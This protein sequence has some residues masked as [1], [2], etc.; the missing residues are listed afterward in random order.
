MPGGIA[1]SLP[2]AIGGAMRKA[3]QE[4]A[5]YEPKYQPKTSLRDRP[6]MVVPAAPS[7]PYATVERRMEPPER[8]A[9]DL[10]Y[11]GEEDEE[12]EGSI[13]GADAAGERGRSRAL[14]ILKA[15][16]KI[17]DAGMWRSLA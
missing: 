2:V 3:R 1:R 15:Q 4:R 6:E 13:A 7:V 16:S 8:G 9:S 11:I 10:G 5:P 14:N 17:P 12:D